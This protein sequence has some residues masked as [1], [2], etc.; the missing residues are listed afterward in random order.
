LIEA[1]ALPLSQTANRRT[2]D[3][4]TSTDQLRKAQVYTELLTIC[5]IFYAKWHIYLTMR[6]RKGLDESAM[7]SVGWPS[8]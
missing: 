8:A 6:G 7:A 2:A 3:S 5:R 1:N 4:T